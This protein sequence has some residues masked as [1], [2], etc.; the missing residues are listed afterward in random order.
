MK[1]YVVSD[2]HGFYSELMDA[3]KVVGFFD[4]TNPH[5]LILCGD[6]MDRGQEAVKTQDFMINLLEENKLIYV[7]GNHEDLMTG[8]LTR[9]EKYRWDITLGSSHHIYNGTW[10]TALQLA[11]MKEIDA[12][13]N[14]NE[15]ISK[16]T[17][18]PFVKRLLPASQNYFETEKYIFVHG[19]IPYRQGTNW[20]HA[21][22]ASW[23]QARWLNGMEIAN[24]HKPTE[25][26]KTIVCGHYHASYGH[27]RIEKTCSEWGKDAD[28]TPYYG[29]GV[30]G[31][32][33][34]TAYTGVVNCIVIED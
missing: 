25:S 12:L 16:V 23:K 15:L 22:N 31:I 30:I 24:T 17:E 4:E 26:N 29:N 7:R 1:Y 11:N 9:F 33:G 18:T 3:L 6:M 20:R 19:W 8:M 5:K 2:V 10:G 34:C 21:E 14:P 28:F 27:S 13:R 32:D